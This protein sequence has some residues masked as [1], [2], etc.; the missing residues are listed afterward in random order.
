MAQITPEDWASKDFE[1]MELFTPGTP[2]D[3]NDLFAGRGGQIDVLI[4]TVFQRGQHAIVYG[5]PGVGKTSL[6]RTFHLKLIGKTKNYSSVMVNCDPSDTFTSIW[7]KVFV[8]YS[9]GQTS[10]ADE[11]DGEI[12]PE[13]VRRTLDR[14]SL[15]TVPIIILDEFNQVKN[16]EAKNLMANT[17]KTLSDYSSRA[18]IVI[19]GVANSVSTL[20]AEHASISRAL[21]QIQMPRMLPQELREIIEKRLPRV[22]MTISKGALAQIVSLSR[23]LPHYTHLLGQFS[24]R[25]AVA[26]KTMTVSETHVDEGQRS[27]LEKTHQSIREQYHAATQSPRSGNIYKQV[28]LAGA[29]AETDDLGFF[30]AKAVE[31]PLTAIMREPYD[32]SKFG[33]HLKILCDQN[34]GAILF[35]TGEPRRYRYRFVDPMMQ[36][37]I[38]I[39][40]LSENLIDKQMLDSIAPNPLQPRLSNDF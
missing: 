22:G 37:Y 17:I 39:R 24:A 12:T 31:A 13:D 16:L 23:G 15:N 6:A 8:D 4:E 20:I 14:F 18:T 2:I 26:A 27:C 25:K 35:Q 11:F 19:V 30:P 3:E 5:E 21:V 34:R 40:G 1:L 29:L 10:V 28:L 38:I 33:Q 32:T 7:K 9:D 36:P